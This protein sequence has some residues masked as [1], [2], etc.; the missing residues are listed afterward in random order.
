MAQGS[1][2]RPPAAAEAVAARAVA[3]AVVARVEAKAPTP[4]TSQDDSGQ[5]GTGG[6]GGAGGGVS[7]GL[8]VLVEDS[9][10]SEVETTTMMMMTPTNVGRRG[11]MANHAKAT[12]ST[13]GAM[14]D[15]VQP[16]LQSTRNLPILY[17]SRN[18]ERTELGFQQCWIGLSYRSRA[19][20]QARDARPVGK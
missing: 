11:M 8:V 2:G 14:Q 12:H 6:T 1:A 20:H 10:A 18:K 5:G 13:Q 19:I 15:K 9:Q 4:G 17:I 3:K 7:R 16:T